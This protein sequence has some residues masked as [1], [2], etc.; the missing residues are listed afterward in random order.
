LITFIY[1]EAG[2]ASGLHATAPLTTGFGS[3]APLGFG[4]GA[5]GLGYG[6][7]GFAPLGLGLAKAPLATLAAAPLAPT[8]GFYGAPALSLAA[9]LPVSPQVLEVEGDDQPVHVVF[10]SLSSRVH[11][12]Q[13]HTP[14]APGQ[15]ETTASEDE[16]HVVRH[17]VMRPVIQEIRE[18]IQ[19]YRR[20]VQEVRPVLEEI[21]TVVA[22]GHRE[23]S[24]AAPYAA[25]PAL[26]RPA[27]GALLSYGGRAL[28]GG[29]YGALATGF[30]ASN[31][32]L[33]KSKK[34]A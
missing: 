2:A 15:I 17:Q 7:I 31:L 4:Y 11:V 8:Y 10:K 20:V 5:G 18:V 23:G 16:P 34:A 22:K 3:Y 32:K 30:D 1:S 24:L 28:G 33:L 29:S 14:G 12:Q 25:A 19:P 13:V 21:H 6:A 27:N 9:P 26:A